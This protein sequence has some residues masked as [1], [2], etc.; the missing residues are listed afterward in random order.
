MSE[1]LEQGYSNIPLESEIV[2]EIHKELQRFF[3][4]LLYWFKVPALRGKRGAVPVGT[5]D[6]FLCI[7]GRFVAI[8]V[9]RPGRKLTPEQQAKLSQIAASGAITAVVHSAEEARE[10]LSTR[11][12]LNGAQPSGLANYPIDGECKHKNLE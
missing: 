8:E 5:P 10:L 12:H 1:R 9:K 6:V 4:P 11:V 2:D 3:G 7:A